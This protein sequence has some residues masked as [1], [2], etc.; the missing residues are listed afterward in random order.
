MVPMFK[1]GLERSKA[2]AETRIDEE[3]VLAP[4]DIGL[5]TLVVKNLGAKKDIPN[6][7]RCSLSENARLRET[8]SNQTK[9][10]C[11]KEQSA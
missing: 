6:D 4:I 1:C 2:A 5:K 3:K 11:C 8:N 10:P 7:L 9:Y